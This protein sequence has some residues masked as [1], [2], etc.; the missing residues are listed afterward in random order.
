MVS[1]FFTS[2]QLQA[3]IFSGLARAMRTLLKVKGSLGFWKQ[4]KISS[5]V[6]PPGASSDLKGQQSRTF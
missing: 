5:T 2:P 3:L 1:G 6:V 4:L